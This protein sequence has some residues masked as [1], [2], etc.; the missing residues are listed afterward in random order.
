[1]ALKRGRI[2]QMR[3]SWGTGD[4][5]LNYS[6]SEQGGNKEQGTYHCQSGCSSTWRE[7]GK[8]VRVS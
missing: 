8:A 6:V 5:I 1:M 7:F 3:R 4:N 2:Y